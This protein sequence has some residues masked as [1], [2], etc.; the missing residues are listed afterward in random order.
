MKKRKPPGSC[1]SRSRVHLQPRLA[2]PR[3]PPTRPELICLS[4][5]PAID[6]LNIPRCG[7]AVK[8]HYRL[9]KPGPL[10]TQQSHVNALLLPA[11][12]G[13]CLALRSPSARHS[14]SSLPAASYSPRGP[15]ALKIATA[16]SIAR[17]CVE[18]LPPRKPASP[19]VSHLGS[20]HRQATCHTSRPV[21]H[22]VMTSRFRLAPVE[23]D[24]TLRCVDC[25]L[26]PR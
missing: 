19:L 11:K 5:L 1:G 2:P 12:F 16:P 25:R 20:V 7:W 14:P 26:S 24:C 22:A 17:P 6:P 3:S 13:R 18:P 4:Q 21:P 8:W 10:A 15:R 23:S 9:A